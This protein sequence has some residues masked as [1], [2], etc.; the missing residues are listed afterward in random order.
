MR[1]QLHIGVSGAR[2]DDTQSL[3]STVLD[4]IVPIGQTLNL[5]LN[6]NK[7]DDCGFKY[8]CTGTLLCPIVLDWFD[9]E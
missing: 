8:E 3:K 7:K 2:G 5:L 4:W 1:P 9:N 6:Q